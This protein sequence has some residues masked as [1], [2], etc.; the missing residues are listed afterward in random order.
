MILMASESYISEIFID[1]IAST[2][3]RQARK[4][5]REL[6]RSA[7]AIAGFMADFLTGALCFAAA[8]LLVTA[9]SGFDATILIRMIALSSV[10]G[11]AV[12]TLLC[13]R[14]PTDPYLGMRD[15]GN[16]A[17]AVRVSIQAFLIFAPAMLFLR[18]RVPFKVFV[19]CFFLLP[20]ALLFQKQVD[21]R[22][23]RSLLKYGHGFD[24]VVVYGSGAT[25]ERLIST[26]MY[27]PRFDWFPVAVIDLNLDTIRKD[28]R[29]VGGRDYFPVQIP[30]SLLTSDLLRLLRCDVLLIAEI[31]P[32]PELERL[33]G[34]AEETGARFAY[35][36]QDLRQMETST[37][38]AQIGELLVKQEGKKE[39]PWHYAY[40]KRIVDVTLSFL[41]LVTL[42][43]LLLAIALIIRLTSHGPALFV[44][45]RVGLNGAIFRMYKFRSMFAR[46]EAYERSPSSSHDPR[47]TSVGRFLRRTS[48]DELPQL[49]NV[50]CGQM[51]LVGPRPEMPFIVRSYTAYQW[52]RLQVIPGLTG[53]W[54]LS[55]DRPYAIHENLQHDFAYIR[56]RDLALDAA[57]LIHTLFFAMRGGI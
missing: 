55:D 23:M 29:D 36:S 5:V 37:H 45:E 31:L 42:S 32:A 21:K 20:I 9:G 49:I 53:L 35:V 51:S 17:W 30:V 46:T 25:S 6:L 8:Y 41:L 11:I 44:Q 3:A 40:S 22:I 43:P 4:I 14:R 47:I 38:Q 18:A 57:I 16:T 19:A 28:N 24:R 7:A 54:Q 1:P 52:Q 12:A 27:S 56:N 26:L 50:F 48:L 33:R 34:L 39:E 10:S 13:N 15:I 2:K